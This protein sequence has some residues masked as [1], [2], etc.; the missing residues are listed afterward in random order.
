MD[1]ILSARIEESI[2]NRIGLLAKELG[3]SKKSVIE[4]AILCYSEKV[5]KE[6]KIDLFEKTLGA[7]N[8]DETTDETVATIRKEFRKSLERYK[9]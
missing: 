5:S 4:N 8:R 3:T 7:W 9:R 1:K 2:L 6:Y